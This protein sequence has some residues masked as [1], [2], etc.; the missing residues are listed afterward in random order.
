MEATR[1]WF[2]TSHGVHLSCRTPSWRIFP[3][4]AGGH[5]FAFLEN[6]QRFNAVL[7]TFMTR[8]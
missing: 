7:R 6:P 8:P 5:H 1:H 3:E 2:E 4:D